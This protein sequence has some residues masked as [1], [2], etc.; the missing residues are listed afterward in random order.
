[1]KVQSR[2]SEAAAFDRCIN[3]MAGL[4]QKYGVK[5]LKERKERVIKWMCSHITYPKY[6]K[7]AQIARF[8]KYHEIS[9]VD[10]KTNNRKK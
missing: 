1:M 6:K 7:E 3:V 2:K 5:V 4:M 10:R 9:G 8:T